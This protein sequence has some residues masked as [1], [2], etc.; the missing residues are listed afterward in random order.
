MQPFV[1]TLADVLI[2]VLIRELQ[3]EAD[4]DGMPESDEVEQQ[5]NTEEQVAGNVRGA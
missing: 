2:A 1:Q 3:A 4:L 5:P